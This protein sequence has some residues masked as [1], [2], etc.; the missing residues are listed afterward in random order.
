MSCDDVMWWCHVMMSCDVMMSCAPSDPTPLIIK[1]V[2]LPL[3][4]LLVN[5]ALYCY[6]KVWHTVVETSG[7]NEALVCV[8]WTEDRTVLSCLS[9]PPGGSIRADGRTS[10]CVLITWVFLLQKKELR[11]QS[12]SSKQLLYI[13]MDSSHDHQ[14]LTF[15]RMLKCICHLFWLEG[16]FKTFDCLA[17]CCTSGFIFY[18]QE[19]YLFHKN[20]S[21]FCTFCIDNIL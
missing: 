14:Q 12:S 13:Q 17:H 9:R 18:S 8:W 2:V 15:I 4:L 20:V 21:Y 16:N 11:E 10:S 1:A 5:T 19:F 6:C 7:W 3:A